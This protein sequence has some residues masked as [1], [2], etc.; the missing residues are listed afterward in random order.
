MFTT[1]LDDWKREILTL[2][3]IRAGYAAEGKTTDVESVDRALKYALGQYLEK[4]MYQ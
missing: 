4:L 2:I 3:K 1:G